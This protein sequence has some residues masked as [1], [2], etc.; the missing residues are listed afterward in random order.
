M[1]EAGGEERDEDL[2]VRSASE[3]VAFSVFYG[4]HA[5]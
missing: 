3:P 1:A 5:N 2:L 4:R